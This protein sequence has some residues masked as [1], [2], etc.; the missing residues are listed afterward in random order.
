[1][2]LSRAVKMPKTETDIA[3]LQVKVN[4]I[5]SDISE[6]KQDLKDVVTSI[7]KN[8]EETHKML[9][10]MST[11]STAAH[12]SMSDKISSLE[13]WRWML[14]GAGV[15]LGALGHNMLGSLLK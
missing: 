14:M 12:S 2:A 13:K 6:I 10:E 4:N 11:A 7:S 8:N 5:E 9:K 1:M 15:V 3:V